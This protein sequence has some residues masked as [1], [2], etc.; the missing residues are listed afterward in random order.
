MMFI[1][2]TTLRDGEQAPGVAFSVE[3]KI[4]IARLLDESG[5]DEIEAGTP[6]MGGMELDAVRSIA[7][8]GLSARVAAWNRAVLSDIDAS[9]SAGVDIVSI[10]LPVSDIQITNKLAS[11][12]T[13]VLD[14][15]VRAVEY[16]KANGLYVCVGA[17]DASRADA[18]FLYSY[19]D[20]AM[21]AGADRL[22]FSDTVGVLDPFR[23]FEVIS[24]LLVRTPL[25][26]E[27]HAHN[28][29]GLAAANALAGL[30]AGAGWVSTTVLGLGERAGNAALEEVAMAAKNL[31]GIET[32]IDVSRLKKLCDYT[33]K[34]S[35]RPVGPGKPVVGGSIFAHESG[36]HADG[37][38]K[39]PGL[40]E[41][42]SPDMVGLSREIA[43]GKHSG[44]A[45][46][47]HRFMNMGIL[48]DDEEAGQIL[49][50]V[51]RRSV[52]LKRS[53][54]DSDL[55]RIRRALPAATR[56]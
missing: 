52:A 31:L 9:I 18:K 25:P 29:F 2:D 36:I 15:L 13:G 35:G 4:A 8:L 23:M 39:H 55:L 17:E 41:A 50:E 49:A 10:S 56:M 54:S 32:R 26:I 22:R 20:V 44:R 6:A 30:R 14:R 43:I 5:V 48:I 53:L 51:R 46:L 11:D 45:G 40:Y 12:R 24:A 42:Y 3:E 21:K 19:A 38:L 47:V 7:A 33:A 1:S 34:A 16:A 27:V 28:D 37:V